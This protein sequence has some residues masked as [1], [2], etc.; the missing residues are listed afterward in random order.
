[1]IHP[2]LFA[3][4]G[5]EV[6]FPCGIKI[7]ANTPEVGEARESLPVAL[8]RASA[9]ALSEVCRGSGIGRGFSE[10]TVWHPRPADVAWL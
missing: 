7:T 10:V 9:A 2:S 8:Q 4:N 1:L 6:G 5:D 3:A